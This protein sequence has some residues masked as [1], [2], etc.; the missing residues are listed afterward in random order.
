[1]PENSRC[2]ASGVANDG[3]DQ[4]GARCGKRA[5]RPLRKGERIPLTAR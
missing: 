1:M 2:R 3:T 4:P 5:G